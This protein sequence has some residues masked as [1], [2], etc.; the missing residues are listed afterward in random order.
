M[1]SFPNRPQRWLLAAVLP[2][3]L[4]LM[5]PDLVAAQDS[6]AV[7]LPALVTTQGAAEIRVQPDRADLRFDIEVRHADLTSA[8]REQAARMDR[9]IAALRKAGVAEADLAT[10]QLQLN[11]LYAMPRPGESGGSLRIDA[12]SVSQSVDCTLTQVEKVADVTSAAIRAGATGVGEVQL[13]TSELKKHRDE[14]R[15]QAI[16]A[17]RDKAVLLAGELGSKVGK[18]YQIHEGGGG[19]GVAQMHMLA[20]PRL[21]TLSAAVADMAPPTLGT[22]V[23]GLITVSA[24]VEVAFL[25]E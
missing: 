6:P 11:V 7:V 14:V 9:L 8:R 15:K 19:E 13:R 23:S 25:L 24:G 21:A 3:V 18:P 20:R 1:K 22:F 2:A 17:A 10:T 16:R 4:L 12:Y 5:T